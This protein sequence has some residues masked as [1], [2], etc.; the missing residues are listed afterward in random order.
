MFLLYLGF[1]KTVTKEKI[2][3]NV[4]ETNITIKVNEEYA[5]VPVLEN[6]TYTA[7]YTESKRK[8]TI[9]FLNYNGSLLQSSQVEYGVMPEYTGVTP[10]RQSSAQYRQI[11][12][13]CVLP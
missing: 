12:L 8:Y 13:Q 11:Q 6:A 7:T 3:F 4:E 10:A 1:L 5:F 2:K 9:Q